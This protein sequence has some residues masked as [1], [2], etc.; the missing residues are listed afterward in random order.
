VRQ[1]AADLGAPSGPDDMYLALRGLR[2]IKV[3]M[4]R[5]QETGIMLA[6]WLA[7]RPEVARVLHPALPHDPGHALWRR[8]FT[9]ACGL[10]SIVLKPTR[11]AQLA[12]MVDGLELYGMGASWGGFES[13]ILPSDPSP[14]RSATK[15]AAPGP[16]VRIHAGLEDP[17]DLIAD[18]ESGFERLAHG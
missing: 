16:L 2:T 11:E 3:R 17:E 5:H 9:G 12:A 1:A 7:K 8:D 18:L 4:A 13:L 10:F 14:S 6:H 15:W